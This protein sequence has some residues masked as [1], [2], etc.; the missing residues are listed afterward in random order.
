M[1]PKAAAPKQNLKN[2]PLF[3]GAV[4][5]AVLRDSVR[6]HVDFAE[7]RVDLAGT[8]W[9]SDTVTRVDVVI[10]GQR[11]HH[12]VASTARGGALPWKISVLEL[13]SG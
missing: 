4:F 7:F 1:P 11:W 2:V 8:R 9:M 13:V 10:A 12:S 6:A 3:S 5:V